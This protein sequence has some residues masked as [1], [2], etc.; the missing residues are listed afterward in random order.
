MDLTEKVCDICGKTYKRKLHRFSVEFSPVIVSSHA[1]VQIE[2][3]RTSEFF[4]FDICPI[5]AHRILCTIIDMQRNRP[6]KCE[7]CEFDRGPRESHKHPDCNSC[8]S[9]FHTDYSNFQLKKRMHVRQN[10]EWQQYK[11]YFGEAD[12]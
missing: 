11:R 2:G 6:I 5:C 1:R 10:Y 12:E 4:D 9:C 3:D 8:W 7:F